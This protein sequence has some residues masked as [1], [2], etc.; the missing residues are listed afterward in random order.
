MIRILNAL[1]LLLMLGGAAMIALALMLLF[2]GGVPAQT[3]FCGGANCPHENPG[4]PDMEKILTEATCRG[5]W[6]A[7]IVTPSR[8]IPWS[9][10]IAKCR[11]AGLHK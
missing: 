9:E 1:A 10:T 5:E 4:A 11:R 8:T 6:V 2:S 7:P 3:S